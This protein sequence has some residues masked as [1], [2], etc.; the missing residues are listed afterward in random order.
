M[1][2]KKKR[3]MKRKSTEKMMKS[4]QLKYLGIEKKKELKKENC[5]WWLKHKNGIKIKI[6]I[7]KTKR[8]NWSETR[9][10]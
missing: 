6:K 2:M 4:W 9:R 5:G 1:Q 3:I 10:P 7:N 8:N